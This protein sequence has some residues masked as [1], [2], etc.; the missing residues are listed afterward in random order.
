MRLKKYKL[1]DMGT[2]EVKVNKEVTNIVT[3]FLH[4]PGL[5]LG[6]ILAIIF[7][8]IYFTQDFLK[9]LIHN[10][11]TE[12]IEKLQ[13][14]IDKLS[15]ETLTHRE[16]QTKRFDELQLSLSNLQG[17]V[18][19]IYK[20][21]SVSLIFNPNVPKDYRAIAFDVAR[22]FNLNHGIKQQ[23]KEFLILYPDAA[24]QSNV[25]NKIL[26]LTHEEAAEMFKDKPIPK[27][28]TINYIDIEDNN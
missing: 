6:V 21:V 20:L 12:G 19:E 1:I 28:I 18:D 10:S 15:S 17:D 14:S 2:K 5:R 9:E 3:R 25:K 13:E 23:Y 24:W 26:S 11:N 4:Y 16:L 7:A 22:R 27:D 8:G